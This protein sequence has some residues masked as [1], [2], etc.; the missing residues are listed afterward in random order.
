[1]E[2]KEANKILLKEI[3]S[4]YNRVPEKCYGA[5]DMYKSPFRDEKAASF[6]VNKN[7]NKWA[8]LG[9]GSYGGVV[10]LVMKLECCCFLDAMKKIEEREFKVSPIRLGKMV[11]IVLRWLSKI[12]IKDW[13]IEMLYLKGVFLIRIFLFLIGV[14]LN[15][16]CLKAFLICFLIYRL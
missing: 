14:A 2:S 15:V 5:Y 13:S 7:T 4:K 9:D 11:R 12:K 3:L 6:K 16:L 1:M 10:D 8:D